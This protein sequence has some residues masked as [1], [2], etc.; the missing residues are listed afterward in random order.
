MSYIQHIRQG[1]V[2]VN[3]NNLTN[4]IAETRHPCNDKYKCM[5]KRENN[6]ACLIY[7]ILSLFDKR[8]LKSYIRS[9][10]AHCWAH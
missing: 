8:A 5:L 3:M 6:C 1:S 9:E 10:R 4:F 7:I 2:F